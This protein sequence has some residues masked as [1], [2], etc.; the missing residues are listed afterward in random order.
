MEKIEMEG[1]EG[2]GDGEQQEG[3]GGEGE[4]LAD[5]RPRIDQCRYTCICL[6]VTREE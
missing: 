1:V 2:E 4:K 6:Y 3:Y 5:H